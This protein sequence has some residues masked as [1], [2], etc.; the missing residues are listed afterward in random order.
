MIFS[1]PIFN[2]HSINQLNIPNDT[3]FNDIKPIFF[4]ILKSIEDNFNNE[5]LSLTDYNHYMNQISQIYTMFDNVNNKSIIYHHLINLGC[6]VGCNDIIGFIDLICNFYKIKYDNSVFEFNYLQGFFKLLKLDIYENQFKNDINQVTFIKKNKNSKDKIVITD[7]IKI[8]FNKSNILTNNKIINNYC[9]KI[10][11]LFTNIS[12]NQLSHL[13]VL[14]GYFNTDNIGLYKNLNTGII[15]NKIDEVKNTF[16]N[17]NISESYKNN[18]IEFINLNLL[19]STSVLDLGKKMIDLYKKS[20]IWINKNISDLSKD[21]IKLD[22][23]DKFDVLNSILLY[24]NTEHILIIN[25]LID[26]VSTQY[27]Y[28]TSLLFYS[29]N[30]WELIKNINIKNT[31]TFFIEKSSEDSNINYDKKIQM[32]KCNDIIKTKAYEKYKEIQNNKLGEGSTKAQI[33]LDG[34]LKIPFGIYKKDFLR[35]KYDNLFIK[36]NKIMDNLSS[37]IKTFNTNN[38]CNSDLKLIKEL[39][40]QIKKINDTKINIVLVEKFINYINTVIVELKNFNISITDYFNNSFIDELNNTSIKNLKELCNNFEISY[41][42]NKNTTIEL[43]NKRNFKYSDLKIL[44][45]IFNIQK[46]NIRQND[47]YFLLISILEQL[48]NAWTKYIEFK[49]KYISDT[50]KILDNSIYG[51]ND[52]KKQIKR[53]FAQWIHGTDQG[54]VIGLE[55]PP[56]TGKTTIAKNG[57]APILKDENEQP[58]PVVFIP[59]G[60]SSNGSTLEGHNYTY[61]GSTWGKIVDGLI[62]SKC[63]NPIIYIDELDKISKTEHG[64]EIIGILTHMTDPAQNNE[65]TDKYFSGIKFDL[66]KAIIIF[67]YNDVELIDKILLDR[68]QRI[69]IPNLTKIDKLMIAKKHII[70]EVISNIGLNIDDILIDDEILLH[71]IDCYTLEAGARKLKEKLYEI[72]RDINLQYLIGNYK[73]PFKLSKELI[74][75]ILDITNKIDTNMIHDNPRIGLMN[76]LYA[77]S[78]GLGGITKIEAFTFPSTNHLELKLTGLQGDVM[79]ESMNV[80]KTIAFNI[81]PIDIYNSIINSNDKYGIHIHC[82]DGSTP[83][84]GPSAGTAITIAIISLLCKIPIKNYVAI[85]G[86]ID[87]NGNILPIGGL[88]SKLDGAKR[89]GILHAYYPD[90]N[91]INIDKI[92]NNNLSPESDCFSI[93][94]VS[95]IYQALDYCLD[96]NKKSN[97]YFRTI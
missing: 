52:V 97:E 94:P 34:L 3:E 36:I 49:N 27:N 28:K 72:F 60:G 24:N 64:K 54:C 82:P 39:E 80:A 93:N 33:F 16:D 95:N 87:L 84:D 90:K 43:I 8:L 83:K 37:I 85:T 38:L 35:V 41:N 18:F 74:D 81:I 48:T 88:Q 92:R 89:A 25:L 4:T 26:L 10:Y 78:N 20:N 79:K 58:R 47:N 76:G 70:P 73:I 5:I 68:I 91:S 11:I 42:K 86:E 71:L 51:L 62:D 59:L 2:L 56:G 55:G 29:F 45:K 57:I 7:N 63:M 22:L 6:L 13:F 61:V 66:S 30:N 17:I 77:T 40:S 12:N 75:S 31:P 1:I 23:I 14:N 21:F 69:K 96:Y 19:L 65:F 44:N 46:T 32:M 50:F 9:I 53:L 15:M 67:S